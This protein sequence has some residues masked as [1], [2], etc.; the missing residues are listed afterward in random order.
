MPFKGPIEGL[1]YVGNDVEGT[2]LGTHPAVESGFKEFEIV[3][4]VK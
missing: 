2:E 4:E 3:S 1:Y